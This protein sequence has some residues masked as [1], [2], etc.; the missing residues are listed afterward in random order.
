MEQP[1]QLQGADKS[2]R[3][4]QFTVPSSDSPFIF[5]FATPCKSTTNR[6]F[7]RGQLD[8]CG[9]YLNQGKKVTLVTTSQKK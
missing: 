1:I 3:K 2:D 5:I 9:L 6:H 8:L 4:W 7:F